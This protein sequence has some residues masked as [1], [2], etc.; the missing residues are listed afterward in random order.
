M[1]T[2]MGGTTGDSAEALNYKRVR[3]GCLARTDAMCRV[4]GRARQRPKQYDFNDLLARV[5]L[6]LLQ[7]GHGVAIERVARGQQMGCPRI[8][9]SA[10]QA[11]D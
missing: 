7:Q 4:T 8:L 11:I 9:L 10:D 5:G 6:P 2:C 1:V 3:A